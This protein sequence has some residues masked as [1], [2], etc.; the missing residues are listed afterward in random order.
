MY[1][2]TMIED[3][4]A[5]HEHGRSQHPRQDEEYSQDSWGLMERRYQED[6]WDL[7][8]SHRKE[9][10]YEDQTRDRSSRKS[11][12]TSTDEYMEKERNN[13]RNKNLCHSS[14][15]VHIEWP[16]ARDLRRIKGKH[17]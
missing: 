11:V 3:K 13:N 10:H 17:K 14:H 9:R 7:R 5:Y 4:E 1:T 15:R 8:S 6:E 2:P 16:K 12:K